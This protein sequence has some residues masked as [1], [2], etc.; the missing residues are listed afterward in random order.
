M[1]K[2]SITYAI[3]VCNEE[4]ELQ[5][6]VNILEKN[7]KPQD[8][9]VVLFDKANGS[10]GVEEYLRSYSVNKT[11]FSWFAD[12]FD[13]DFAKWKNK[14]KKL[15]NGNYIFFLDADEYPDDFLIQKID[16]IINENM[17]DIIFVPRINTLKGNENE[18]KEY[19]QSQRWNLDSDGQINY[20]D[21]QGRIIHNKPVLGWSGKVHERIIGYKIYA[22]LPTEREFSLHHPKTLEKQIKQNNLY[23]SL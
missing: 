3:T 4:Y 15:C 10:H 2:Q 20:P 12:E 13:G 18:I 5:R 17:V 6:L 11:N 14:L 21:Y 9:I 16:F 22:T 8:D 7:I 1:N 19:I 23:N